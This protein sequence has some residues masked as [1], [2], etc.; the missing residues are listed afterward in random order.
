VSAGGV[1]RVVDACTGSAIVRVYGDRNA[2]DAT[3]AI[4][5]QPSRR[6]VGASEE[7]PAGPPATVGTSRTILLDP[8]ESKTCRT[9]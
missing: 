6:S 5:T 7:T 8:K 1:G 3:V 4:E 9:C 2:V